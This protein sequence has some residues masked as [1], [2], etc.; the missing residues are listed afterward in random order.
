MVISSQGPELREPDVGAR[1]EITDDEPRSL[2]SRRANGVLD[3][4][5]ELAP[6]AYGSVVSLSGK[7]KPLVVNSAD[8]HVCPGACCAF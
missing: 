6:A 5:D 2:A 7:G 1:D 4:T 3:T 8:G